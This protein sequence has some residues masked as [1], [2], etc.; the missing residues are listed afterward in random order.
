MAVCIQGQN[1]VVRPTKALTQGIEVQS[2]IDALLHAFISVL[3]IVDL[4]RLDGQR[5][6]PDSHT[7]AIVPPK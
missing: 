1:R 5:I 6:Q 4:G 2:E 7:G 3:R